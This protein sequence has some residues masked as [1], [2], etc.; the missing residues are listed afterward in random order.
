MTSFSGGFSRRTR[1]DGSATA[2]R[3]T[4]QDPR[5]LLRQTR[6]DSAGGSDRPLFG[7]RLED[8]VHHE[9]LL[10]TVREMRHEQPKAPGPDGITLSQIGAS[11]AAAICRALSRRLN[12]GTY[13]P[14]SPR[15][16]TI[17]SSS[18]RPRRIAVYSV[19]DSVVAKTLHRLL[20]A[21]VDPTFLAASY[22]FRPNRRRE[23][24][25]AEI[26]LD[27]QS[28]RSFV[29]NVDVR[30]AFDNVQHSLL[31]PEL[32]RLG[33]ATE[34]QNVM[35]SLATAG[36]RTDTGIN[37]GCP[38]SPQLLNLV[39]HTALDVLFMGNLASRF[40]RFADNLVVTCHSQ[41]EANRA[42]KQIDARLGSVGMSLRDDAPAIV[43][44]GETRSTNILGFVLD[45]DNGT[46]RWQLSHDV[47]SLL[48][49]HI[50]EETELA[51]EPVRFQAMLSG[52][53]RQ[54]GPGYEPRQ[55]EDATTGINDA[56]MSA[57]ALR[58]FDAEWVQREWRSGW[59]GGFRCCDASRSN[60]PVSVTLR[61]S[62]LPPR[63]VVK[64][65]IAHSCPK[66]A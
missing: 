6:L 59:D 57:Q 52:L 1:R 9:E 60:E 50:R 29:V 23:E 27:A 28:G 64:T 42:L 36:N 43:Y 35:L 34:L 66:T 7:R 62:V 37:Q 55:V 31:R 2:R 26:L 54:L 47:R 32:T 53:L 25:L 16:V 13:R 41:E 5:R 30:Q 63:A 51:S 45:R 4:W 40:Y 12:A 65:I 48:E 11:D 61:G 22:G 20:S 14:A 3:Q 38:L 10:A 58:R 39:L 17:P 33:C 56:L 49:E 21:L 44:V 18:G 8:I 15:I 24:M 46:L 19:A